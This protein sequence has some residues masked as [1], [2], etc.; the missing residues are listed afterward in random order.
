FSQ[1]HWHA[2][3][4]AL[5]R[6][7]PGAKRD[8]GE[9]IDRVRSWELRCWVPDRYTLHAVSARSGKFFCQPYYN[10][11]QYNFRLDHYFTQKDRL[12]LSYY[13]DS[14]DQQQPSQRVGLQALNIMRNRYGQADF[15]HAFSSSLLWESSFAFA[16]LGGA[17]GQD[18]DLKVPEI[19][20]AD[21]SQGFNIG[22]G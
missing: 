16:S 2:D 5:L 19:F 22:S 4:R 14:F 3:F 11:L 1:L 15:T 12:Y 7:S 18:A 13:N 17:N 20:L 10:A 6:K 8:N 9:R 21:N